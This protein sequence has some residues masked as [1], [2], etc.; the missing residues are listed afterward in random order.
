MNIEQLRQLY[1]DTA[2]VT[3]RVIQ[4]DVNYIYW[5]EQLVLSQNTETQD[6]RVELLQAVNQLNEAINTVNSIIH[7]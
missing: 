5:L 6:H 4:T 7:N 3:P 1:K 2:K